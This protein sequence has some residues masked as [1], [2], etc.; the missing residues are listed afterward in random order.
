MPS[1]RRRAVD[2]YRVLDA[3]RLDSALRNHLSC[4]L[5]AQRQGE[6]DEPGSRTRLTLGIITAES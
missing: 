6:T 1:L 5:L 2:L 4:I 3:L